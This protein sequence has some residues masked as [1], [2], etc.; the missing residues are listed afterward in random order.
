MPGSSGGAGGG[1]FLPHPPHHR[2]L[3]HLDFSPPLRMGKSPSAASVKKLGLFLP[4][5]LKTWITIPKILLESSSGAPTIVIPLNPPLP[6]LR[7]DWEPPNCPK[8][9]RIRDTCAQ[10]GGSRWEQQHQSLSSL[11]KGEKL[12]LLGGASAWGGVHPPFFLENRKKE[13]GGPHLSGASCGTLSSTSHFLWNSFR[14]WGVSPTSAWFRG[15]A[16]APPCREVCTL[17][18]EGWDKGPPNFLEN[19]VPRE[20]RTPGS[21]GEGGRSSHVSPKTMRGAPLFLPPVL[22]VSLSPITDCS[23]GQER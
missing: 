14:F 23:K 9:R 13:L 16:Y 8:S 10:V 7:K 11:G 15:A 2:A 6:P 1:R 18:G 12:K 5:G 20:R 4:S 17:G 22:G 21:G 19:P 3:P